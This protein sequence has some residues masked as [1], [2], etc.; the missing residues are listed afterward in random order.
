MEYLPLIL[1][2]GRHAD[3]EGWEP[4]RSFLVRL[5]Y[6]REAIFC[7]EYDWSKS[8][9]GELGLQFSEYAKKVC[10]FSEQNGLNIIAHSQGSVVTR[11]FLRF[12]GGSQIVRRW[13]SLGGPNHGTALGYLSALWDP[14]ARE[15]T[16]DSWLMRQLNEDNETPGPTRYTTLWSAGDEQVCPPIST[17]LDGADNIEVPAMA[18]HA[19]LSSPVVFGHILAALAR[20]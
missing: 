17:R 1:V 9:V 13:I 10:A 8:V 14:G 16:P 19:L 15:I 20:D 11:W 7:W 4:L 5:G 18:H 2:H 6:P 3:P 12:G